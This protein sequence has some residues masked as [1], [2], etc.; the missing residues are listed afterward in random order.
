MILFY[1][2]VESVCYHFIKDFVLCLYETF[3]YDVINVQL[4]L[5]SGYVS[6]QGELKST[7]SCLLQKAKDSMC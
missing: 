2:L 4:V 3:V 6:L 1:M 7:V 5:E